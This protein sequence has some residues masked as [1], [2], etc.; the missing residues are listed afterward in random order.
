MNA[1]WTGAKA[2][3]PPLPLD[4][5][6]PEMKFAGAPLARITAKGAFEGYASLFGVVD[7]GRD[8]VAPGAFRETL[9]AR[10]A[11][12]V[13]L[14]W[15][16]DPSQP[17]GVWREIAEDGR[18]LKVRGQL[19]LAVAKAREAHAL[20]RSGAVDGLSIGFRPSGRAATRA[21]ASGGSRSSISGRSRSSPSRCCRARASRRSRPPSVTALRPS[22]PPSAARR[23]AS[24]PPSEPS[25]H[26]IKPPTSKEP[27]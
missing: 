23:R 3:V 13:K 12:A 25:R 10:P 27:T 4:L 9:A 15:Q 19:D 26:P 22:P 21:P 8:L 11:G 14:L 7:L 16:H 17:L 2:L 24:P 1:A 5:L 18:G 6:A 20:M